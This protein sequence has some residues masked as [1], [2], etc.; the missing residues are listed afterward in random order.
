ME[1]ALNGQG[2]V[3]KVEDLNAVEAWL[4]A[5]PGEALCRDVRR[6]LVSTLNLADLLPVSAVWAGPPARILAWA[7]KPPLTVARTTGA[8]PFRL[9]LHVG[10]VGHAMVVGPDRGGEERVL[11]AFLA[12]QWFRYPLPR[13]SSSWTRDA[14]ARAATFAAGGVPAGARARRRSGAAALLARADDPD[15]RAWAAERGSRTRSA[16]PAAPRSRRGCAKRSGGRSARW[17]TPRPHSGRSPCSARWCR[18][19]ASPRRWSRLP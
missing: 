5:L 13:G 6:P 11:L 7:A 2:L 18:T 16:R 3:A 4:G 8:T 19:G 12:L 14:A 10:D 15:A 17:R 9:V 1:A